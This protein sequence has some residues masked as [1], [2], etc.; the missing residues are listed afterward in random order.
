MIAEPYWIDLKSN[1]RLAILPRPRGGDWLEDE[2][3][4]WRDAGF[5]VVVSMLTSEEVEELCLEREPEFCSTE[6]IRLIEVPIPDR[7]VPASGD[8]TLALIEE[9]ERQLQKGKTVGV[10]CRQGVG[11]S[12][13]IAACVLV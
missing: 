13:L 12:S 10:H 6:R 11:R 2:V 9:L 3:S 5:D 8:S 4:S 1:G 7:G